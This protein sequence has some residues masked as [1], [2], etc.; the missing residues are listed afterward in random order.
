MNIRQ[1]RILPAREKE[2]I[3]AASFK[4]DCVITEL[5]KS[6]GVSV[7]TIYGWRTKFKTQKDLPRNQHKINCTK[8]VPAGFIAQNSETDS[9][10]ELNVGL[11]EST[12]LPQVNRLL[13]QKIELVFDDM[14]LSMTGQI[15]SSKVLG[16]LRLFG[17]AC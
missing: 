16:I 17:V 14:T 6:Y 5:A 11:R 15:P 10:V 1:R 12:V 9:F 2:L 13:L 7:K 8:T 4:K 3:V